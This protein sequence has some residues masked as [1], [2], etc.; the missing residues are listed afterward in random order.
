MRGKKRPAPSWRAAFLRA[1]AESANVTLAASEAGANRSRLYAERRRDPAFAGAWDQAVSGARLRLQAAGQAFPGAGP[2]RT[3]K[4]QGLEELVRWRSRVGPQLSRARP[5]ML[6][7]ASAAAFLAALRDCCNVR[8]SCA[9]AKVRPGTVYRQRRICPDFAAAWAE[10]LADGYDR[11]EMAMVGA[12][13]AVLEG[14]AESGELAGMTAATA[15]GLLNFHRR[16]MNEREAAPPE[17]SI[18]EVRAEIVQRL[19]A[20]QAAGAI[21]SPRRGE[22]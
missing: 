5:G 2:G 21:P 18:E 20:M 22:G 7:A 16:A 6:T 12:A 17:P 15:L 8:L 3:K 10:A 4:R 1:L 11:V 9:A 19:A 14:D 13:A